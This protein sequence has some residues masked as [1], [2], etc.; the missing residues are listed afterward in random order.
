MRTIYFDMDGTIANLYGVENWLP[1]LRAED[2]TP[3][4]DAEPMVNIADFQLY[5][6]ILQNRGYKIG[7]I[8]WLAKD[9]SKPYKI[10]VTKAKKEWLKKTFPDIVFNETH[11]VQYGTRKDYVAKDKNGI[12]F[13]DDDRV[14][15]NWKGEAINPNLY[16]IVE[17]LKKLRKMSD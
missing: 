15:K 16:D 3:Y 13:D 4:T 17:T 8:S 10:A 9:S 1:K 12:L 5:L 6:S 14:R 7:V 11:F 2:A